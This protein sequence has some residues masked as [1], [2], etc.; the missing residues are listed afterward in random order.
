MYHIQCNEKIIQ[1]SRK[2]RFVLRPCA[3]GQR[4]RSFSNRQPTGVRS[5]RVAVVTETYPPEVNG[6]AMTIGRMIAGLRQR[7]SPASSSCGR[8]STA[9]ISP[10]SRPDFEEVLVRGVAIPRYDM[11]KLGLPA[12]RALLRLW[13]ADRARTSCTS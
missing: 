2:F 9:T 6:V 1:Y 11:L 4:T 10:S 5:L 7:R 12:E 8:A 3:H 13:S